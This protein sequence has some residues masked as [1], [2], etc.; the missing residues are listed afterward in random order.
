MEKK[1]ILKD[2]FVIPA[3]TMFSKGPNKREYGGDNYEAII[4]VSTDETADFTIY[5]LDPDTLM[6]LEVSE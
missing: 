3:G 2:D 1:Y 5:L 6:L 4:E